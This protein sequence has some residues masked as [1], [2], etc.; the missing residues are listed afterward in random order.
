M[1]SRIYYTHGNGTQQPSNNV[2]TN[3]LREMLSFSAHQPIYLIV[4]ALNECPN[5]SGIPAPRKY[6]LSLLKD[7]IGLRLPHLRICVTSR[8]E[9]DIKNVLEPLAST[10]SLHDEIGQR[11]DISD[12]VRNYA[13]SDRMMARW[14]SA[15][16]ELVVE[17]LS[18][19]ADGM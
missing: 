12:Y 7:L 10:V 9:I 17:E 19:K 4:D 1:I 5:L 13:S 16:R 3:C 2:L 8:L 15:E 11:K 6:V 14:R 18:K